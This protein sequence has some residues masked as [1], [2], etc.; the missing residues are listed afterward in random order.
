[1]DSQKIK[2]LKESLD[3]ALDGFRENLNFERDCTPR[4]ELEDYIHEVGKQVFYVL[5]EFEDA[6]LKALKD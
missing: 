1:M 6:I 2:A 4:P 5:F 3:E